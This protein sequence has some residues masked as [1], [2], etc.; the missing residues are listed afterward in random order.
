MFKGNMERYNVIQG[1]YI[2]R[3]LFKCEKN[4]KKIK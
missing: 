4:M 2:V 3:K 1:R